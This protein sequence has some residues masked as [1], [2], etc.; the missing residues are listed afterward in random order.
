VQGSKDF[1][2][3]LKK[4]AAFLQLNTGIVC[5]RLECFYKIEKKIFF[6]AHLTFCCVENSLKVGAVNHDRR[7]GSRVVG[8]ATPWQPPGR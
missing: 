7:I 2:Q 6:K 1:L 8:Q 4:T 5:S 3:D